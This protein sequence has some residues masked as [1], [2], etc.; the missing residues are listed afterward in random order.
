MSRKIAV[1]KIGGKILDDFENLKS[2]ITQL[3]HLY[4]D[5]ILD[6]IILIPGG[7]SFANFIREIYSELKFT[8]EIAHWMG[9]IS[10]NYNGLELNKKFPN[11]PTVENF[12]TLKEKEKLFCIFLPY[13]FLKENDKLPHSWDV[14]SDSISL[15]ITRELGLNECFL[16]KDVDGVLDS[17]NKVIKEISTSKLKKIIK[18]EN[19]SE[20]LSESELLK[21]KTTP[22]DP[23]TTTLIDKDKISCIILNGTKNTHRILNYFKS[24]KLEEKIFTKII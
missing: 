7:G 16:I 13:E 6:R 22:I 4:D 20:T 12:E 24:T 18:F 10:M 1:F 3:N 21:K 15:F 23:Y 9:I 17:E 2:T 19:L 14:T 11:L 5:N 8:E